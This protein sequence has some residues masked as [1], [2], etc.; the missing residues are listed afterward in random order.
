MGS[1]QMDMR[2]LEELWK[3]PVWSAKLN[4]D[5]VDNVMRTSRLVASGI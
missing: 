4:G 3:T 2:P 5:N 1:I